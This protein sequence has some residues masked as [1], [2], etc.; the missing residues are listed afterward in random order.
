MEVLQRV[1]YR[2][3]W[4]KIQLQ[5]SVADGCKINQHH[6]SMCFLQRDRGIHGG[7]GGAGSAL[8]VEKS[9][10]TGL[11]GTSLGTTQ[12]C[13]EPGEGLNQCFAARGIIQKLTR[14]GTH[15]RDNVR[16]LV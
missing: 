8:G 16:R 3:L 15:G 11:A 14:S 10:N 9:K 1:D 4:S 12:R 13:R 2:K 7:G 5:C 6:A